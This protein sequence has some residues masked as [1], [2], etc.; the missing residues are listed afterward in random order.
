LTFNLPE[1]IE[2]WISDSEEERLFRTHAVKTSLLSSITIYDSDGEDQLVYRLRYGPGEL[3]RP[4]PT[5][6]CAAGP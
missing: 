5:Q 2:P 1:H 4:P 3:R 6:D